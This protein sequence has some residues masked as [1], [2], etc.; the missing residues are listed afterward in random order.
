MH[1]IHSPTISTIHGFSTRHG[2]VSQT[3]F[4]SLNLGGIDD[5]PENITENRQRALSE[6]HIEFE[7]VS[8][9]GFTQIN[10][11]FINKGI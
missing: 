7:Q 3:P 9:L 2:G 1:W 5:L 4:D 8:Y 10:K 11:V 6:L